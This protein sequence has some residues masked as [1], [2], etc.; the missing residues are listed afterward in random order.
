MVL[1]VLDIFVSETFVRKALEAGRERQAGW[2]DAATQTLL[3]L[4]M[5]S[6]G[7]WAWAPDNDQTNLLVFATLC[8]LVV[9]R[10][11][12]RPESPAASALAPLP[13]FAM[14]V[15]APWIGGSKIAAELTILTLALLAF[16]IGCRLRGKQNERT[17]AA[18][19]EQKRVA[20]EK[21]LAAQAALARLK[22]EADEAQLKRRRLLGGLDADARVELAA[23]LDLTE[24]LKD[25]LATG[26][27]AARAAQY[28][29]EI[30]AH[31]LDLHDFSEDIADL[32]RIE[33]GA[34]KMSPTNIDLQK[35]LS[36]VAQECTARRGD[37][38]IALDVIT[39]PGLPGLLGDDRLVRRMVMR[40]L[41]N[42]VRETL[43][44]GRVTI[45]ALRLPDG[46]LGLRVSSSGTGLSEDDLE[47]VYDALIAGEPGRLTAE[48]QGGL[49]VVVVKALIERHGGSL[50]I[51]TR[52]GAGTQATLNFPP[53]RLISGR[54][55]VRLID[56]A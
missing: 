19:S 15:L 55:L 18:L 26:G 52:L 9:N 46:G 25:E 34:L 45:T 5:A 27:S 2:A 29:A 6:F 11:L 50:S 8:L 53:E 14:L 32:G 30:H 49:G 35:L 38:Q 21:L 28:A 47:R 42:A 4:C 13:I 33:S 51:R 44:G 37:L 40:L 23:M 16:V 56:A 39:F 31:C 41:A 20:E 12:P 3:G 54:P 10:L 24:A 1:F 17:I 22:S 43:P 36:A 48:G 7:I